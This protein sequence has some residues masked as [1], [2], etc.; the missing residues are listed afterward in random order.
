MNI[1]KRQT[2][3]KEPLGHFPTMLVETQQDIFDEPSGQFQAVLVATEHLL[4]L[5]LVKCL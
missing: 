2:T 5:T 4:S 3:L 1:F